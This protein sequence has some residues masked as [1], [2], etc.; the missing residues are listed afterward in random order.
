MRF[1]DILEIARDKISLI[2][3]STKGPQWQP[4]ETDIVDAAFWARAAFDLVEPV[5]FSR[6][7]HRLVTNIRLVR[8]DH[9]GTSYDGGLNVWLGK[10]LGA[11]IHMRY[12][13]FYP[14]SDGNHFIEAINDYGTLYRVFYSDFIAALR[15]L[16]L[17][18]RLQILAVSDVLEQRMQTPIATPATYP[19]PHFTATT[20]GF[21]AL[22]F[23]LVRDEADLK[24]EIMS[25]IFGIA[26]I[27]DGHLSDLVF[28]LSAQEIPPGMKIKIGFTPP[29]E[30]DQDVFSPWFDRGILFQAIRDHFI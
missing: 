10:L 22:L 4:R 5:D 28:F 9:N 3:P 15:T 11:I 16:A 20:V 21:L 26:N 2:D 30:G 18:R 24:R 1:T 13:A 17:T 12:F 6:Y 23:D 7:S 19:E 14:S 27:P 25:K 29:W 8:R